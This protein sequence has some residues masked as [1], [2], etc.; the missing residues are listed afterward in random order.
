[1]IEQVINSALNLRKVPLIQTEDKVI[2]YYNGT[3]KSTKKKKIERMLLLKNPSLKLKHIK[4][5][6]LPEFDLKKL[7]WK[8]LKHFIKLSEEQDFVFIPAYIDIKAKKIRKT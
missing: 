5:I 8:K 2:V 4:V 1:M 7:G 6:A 3:E